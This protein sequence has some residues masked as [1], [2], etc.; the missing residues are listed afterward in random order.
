MLRIAEE[1]AEENGKLNWVYNNCYY[2]FC[3]HEK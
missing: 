1:I 3:R 2:M